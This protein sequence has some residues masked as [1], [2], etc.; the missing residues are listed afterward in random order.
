MSLRLG[1]LVH[2][3]EISHLDRAAMGSRRDGKGERYRH[4]RRFGDPGRA[5]ES[6]QVLECACP[7]ALWR[8]NVVTTFALFHD[9]APKPAAKAVEAH[10]TPGRCRDFRP[11]PTTRQVLEC[12]RPLALWRSYGVATRTS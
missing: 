6:R 12:A 8:S 3:P 11:S 5:L 4:P 9:D 10:R 2:Y 7:L 1:Y